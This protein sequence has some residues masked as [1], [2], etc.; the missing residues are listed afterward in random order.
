MAVRNNC[1]SLYFFSALAVFSSFCLAMGMRAWLP[2][3]PFLA[4]SSTKEQSTEC[5]GCHHTPCCYQL[6]IVG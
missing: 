1:F 5:V 2:L 6:C 3:S 4:A